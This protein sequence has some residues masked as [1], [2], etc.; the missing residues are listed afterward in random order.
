VGNSVTNPRLWRPGWIAAAGGTYALVVGVLTLLGYGL[1]VRRLTDWDDNGISMFPNA[2]ACAALGGLALL[3]LP[4]AGGRKPWRIVVRVIT[5]VVGLLGGLTL[6]EHLTG[7]TLGIDTLLFESQW[8]QRAAAAP[9]RMGPPASTS[10]L[11]IGAG[12]LLATAAPPAR[13]VASALAV[14]IAGIAALSLV[15]YGFGAD[16]LFGVARVTG[17]AYQ[18]SSALA[19]IG[20][21]LVASLPEHGTAEVLRRNDPGGVIARRLLLPIIAIPLALGWLRVRG[22]EA[23]YFDTAFGTALLALVMIVMLFA[24]LWWTAEGVSRQARLTRAAEASVRESEARYR[25]LFEVVVYGVVTID[26]RGVIESANPAVEQLFGYPASEVVGRNVNMLMPE[27]YRLEHDEYIAGYLRTGEAKIIGI[28]REVVG[29]R[30]DGSTF[31]MDLAISEFRLGDCRGFTGIVRDVTERKR[32]EAE[33]DALLMRLTSLVDNT[34]LAVVEWDADFVVTRWAGQA[35][36]VFGWTAA[37]VV[38]KRLGA[39][40]LVHEEDGPKVEAVMA[41]LLDPANKFV[42]SHNRNNTKTG[43]VISCEWYNSTLHDEAGRLKAILSLVLDVTERE[44]AGEALREADRRKDEFLAVLAHDLRNPLAPVRNAIELLRLAG[45]DAGIVERARTIMDRQVAQITRL[46]DDLLDVARIARG[47]LELRRQRVEL[48][49]VVGGAAEAGRPLIDQMGHEFAVTVSPA[50]VYL[51]VDP[52]RVG[53]VLLNLLNNAAKYTPPGGR[54]RL[55]AE[56][57]VSDAVVVVKD[58]GVGIPADKLAHV[59]DMFMQV[60]T[61][62]ERTQGGLG[63]GLTLVKRLVE[64]HGGSVEVAS[65]GPGR[66]SEFTVRLPVVLDPAAGP[67]AGDDTRAAAG[68]RILVVDDHVDGADSLADVLRAL[69][70][71]VVTAYDGV[72]ALRAADAFWPDVVLLDIGLPKLN[73]YEVARRIRGEPWGERTVLVAVTGWGHDDDKVRSQEAGFNSHLVK[74][75]DPPALMRLLG[76]LLPDPSSHSL[77]PVA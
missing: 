22:Q 29:R 73:G 26:D 68:Y 36:R 71:E 23:G 43:T 4:A 48:A 6:L 49:A 60:E 56:R 44:R 12:L 24:L 31:P 59:F 9:M 19:A 57:H 65:D 58:T 64:M 63:L 70:N 42:V 11:I 61:S 30:K 54:I 17:I 38:G 41:R 32:A 77:Q 47:K 10:Y 27:P 37:D 28:G 33:R 62:R 45:G 69:G 20:I 25:T 16:Q 75:V 3:L 13:R 55:V 46:V 40:R 8:G 1:G 76:G 66:G 2:A 34:P 50:P 52:V 39:T 14:V 15:G 35:E 18:T 53:Q 7:V 72:Q 74:P 21:G 67:P 5:G 51:D